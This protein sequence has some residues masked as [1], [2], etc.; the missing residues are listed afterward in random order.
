MSGGIENKSFTVESHEESIGDRD[1]FSSSRNA[2]GSV[3]S[4]NP[5]T[6]RWGWITILN[7]AVAVYFGFA[8]RYWYITY[9]FW[10]GQWC[11]GYGML[12]ILLAIIYGSLFYYHIAKRFF[13]K[14]IAGC[15]RPVLKCCKNV[16]ENK[17]V[18]RFGSAIFYL[19][20][21]AAGIVFLIFDTIDSRDRLIS[22]LGA[23]ILIALGW[24][25]SKHPGRVNWTPVLWGLILQFAIG[26]FTIRWS[27]GREIFQCIADKMT[28]FLSYATEGAIFVFS[29]ELVSEYNVFAFASLTVV[30]FFS[31]IVQ[32]LYYV[33]AMQWFIMKL[34]GLLQII[35]GTTVC[36]SINSV[37]NIFLS[38]SESPLLIKPYIPSLTHSEM[39]TIM[40]SGFAT[41]SGTVLLAYINF[42]AEPAH[43][44]I[45]SVMSAPAALCYSKL[46]YPEVEETKTSRETIAPL[47]SDDTSLLDA[48]SKGAVTGIA[49]FLGIIA[50]VIAFVSAIAFL[51]GIISWLGGLVGYDFITFD[52]MLSKVFIPLAW[53]MGVP[54]EECEM[55]AGLIGLKTAVN[56]FVAFQQL[57]QYKSAKMLSPR[58]E[59][60]AT[61]AI[62]GFSNPG[63]IGIMIGALTSMAPEKRTQITSVAVRA[64]ITGS[65]VCFLTACVAGMLMTDEFYSA[66]AIN[67]TS[68]S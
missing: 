42:G 32:I 13:G 57:G 52:W 24:I 41:V 18:R 28:I 53:I 34:G 47:K 2:I 66:V 29:K 49:L 50:N 4:K 38:M 48:A 33:G 22:L 31:F 64:F 43:L 14:T 26:L 61:Y 58:T 10:T 51:N 12:V 63:S 59:A 5:R 46:F 36:E 68:T 60:I 56:E 30:F 67:S 11:N 16:N 17:Y 19:I 39:H 65:A 23:C 8:T 3:I 40:A 21:F 20:V 15:F 62:C 55:I 45:A 9:G 25:F 44:L 27:T 54:W 7:A 35:M 6:I 1:W 37:A